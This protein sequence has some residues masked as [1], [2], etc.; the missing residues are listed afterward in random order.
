MVVG[1][2]GNRHDARGI[3]G[4]CSCEDLCTR[5]ACCRSHRPGGKRVHQADDDNGGDGGAGDGL[6]GVPGLLAEDGRSLEADEAQERKAH[7]YTNATGHASIKKRIEREYA[8]R[9]RAGALGEQNGEVDDGQNGDLAHQADHQELRAALDTEIREQQNDGN[10]NQR[11]APPGNDQAQLLLKNGGSERA[12]SANEINRQKIVR[13][14]R[15]KAGGGAEALA[16]AHGDIGIERAG[17]RNMR[18]H[19]GEAHREDQQQ[20]TDNNEIECR[21]R[22]VAQHED[23]R[24]VRCR[25]AQRGGCGD[26]QKN[27]RD[28][29]DGTVF[30]LIAL[31]FLIGHNYLSFVLDIKR[32][33]FYK[34]AFPF[35]FYSNLAKNCVHKII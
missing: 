16:Q 27:Q 31:A 4:T 17:I 18:R 30:E 20:N 15:D 14:N 24:R 12:G 1:N 5:C 10:E 13:R 3:G 22:T 33:I 26:N 28:A 11:H 23:K 6:A 35:A 7:T 21:R 32:A 34:E 9:I 2:F 29:A 25:C 8:Q 19:R